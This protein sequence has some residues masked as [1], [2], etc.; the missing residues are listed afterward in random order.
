VCDSQQF[1]VTDVPVKYHRGFQKGL[2]DNTLPRKVDDLRLGVAAAT[3]S[4]PPTQP[5]RRP[6]H[7]RMTKAEAATLAAGAV[8]YDFRDEGAHHAR[9][10]W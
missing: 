9:C 3:A 10:R 8:R 5:R 7:S 6:L 1:K 2:G 4:L